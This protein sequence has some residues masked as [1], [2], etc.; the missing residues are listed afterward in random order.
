MQNNN[1]G[2]IVGRYLLTFINQYTVKRATRIYTYQ[3]QAYIR[4]RVR[5]SKYI[6]HTYKIHKV[7]NNTQH[8]IYSMS[9]SERKVHTNNVGKQGI[10]QAQ[11][12]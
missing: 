11:N 2:Y 12:Q 6:P 9:S 1:Y 3:I 4:T 5:M 8:T 10:F 7:V